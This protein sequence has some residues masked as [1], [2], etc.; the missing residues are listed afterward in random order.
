[1]ETFCNIFELRPLQEDRVPLEESEDFVL[2]FRR[3][4][5]LQDAPGHCHEW[6]AHWALILLTLLGFFALIVTLFICHLLLSEE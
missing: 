3:P 5:K 2:S 6:G 4:S 1:M